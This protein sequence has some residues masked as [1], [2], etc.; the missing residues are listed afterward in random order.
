MIRASNIS[1][2][3]EIVKMAQFR[4]KMAIKNRSISK[5]QVIQS[6]STACIVIQ[7]ALICTIKLK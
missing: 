2:W 3:A 6:S 4:N 1:I 5:Q 7:V